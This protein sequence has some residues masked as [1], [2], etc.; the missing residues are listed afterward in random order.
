MEGWGWGDAQRVACR[1]AH[2]VRT[3][4][5]EWRADR[6]KPQHQD[7]EG[8][9]AL[10]CQSGARCSTSVRARRSASPALPVEIR[11]VG[12]YLAEQGRAQGVALP[13]AAAARRGA[14]P[15]LELLV[16]HDSL[17]ELDGIVD[18]ARDKAKKA[19]DRHVQEA[20]RLAPIESVE[21]ARRETTQRLNE[22]KAR[23]QAEERAALAPFLLIRSPVCGSLREPLLDLVPK[24][25]S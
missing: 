16:L 14:R 23:A 3:Q 21:E 8:F 9:Q 1:D 17:V 19:T 6:A 5:K 2:G 11:G 12:L 24:E 18:E 13:R 25:L 22:L 4:V 20:W 7:Q 10:G 15:D